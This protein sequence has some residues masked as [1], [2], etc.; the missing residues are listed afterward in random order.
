MRVAGVLGRKRCPS[1]PATRSGFAL[2]QR[3]IFEKASIGRNESAWKMTIQL[4][5][6]CSMPA[7]I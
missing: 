1:E 7:R 4:E 5:V 6:A 2:M 3:R